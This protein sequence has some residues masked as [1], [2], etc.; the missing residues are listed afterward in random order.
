MSDRGQ[1]KALQASTLSTN[2]GIT[3]AKGTV[4]L[5]HSVAI[6][7]N[8]SDA[9]TAGTAVTET[10]HWVAPYA[11]K[12][13]NAKISAPIGVAQ[14]AA[15]IATFNLARRTA[16]AA[17]VAIGSIHTTTTTGVALTAFVPQAL[18]LTAANC[19][20]AAG[21]VLTFAIVKGSSGVA[22]TAATSY[23]DLTVL[24]EAI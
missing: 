13:V 19:T 9:A 21:D 3:D 8:Y 22:V 18:T 15:N 11:C 10:V 2:S 1:L 16:G 14:A 24:V 20:L 12:V 4:N 23:L 6:T 5:A 17:S 7:K